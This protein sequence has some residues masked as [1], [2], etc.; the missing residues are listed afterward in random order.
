MGRHEKTERLIQAAHKI[1]RERHPMTVRQVY[2]QLVSGHVIK[3]DR[4]Q[5][6]AVSNALVMA[7]RE[8]LIPWN[9]IEDRIRKPRMVSM[10]N[11]VAHFAE[12][13]LGAYRLN[14][15]QTQPA[16]MEVWLE[17]DALSGIF[18]DVLEEYGVTLNVGRGYDGWSSI[19]NAARRYQKYQQRG[20][21]VYVS[22]WGDFDPS[23]EDMVRSL[24]ERLTSLGAYP[25]IAKI[26]LTR[27]DIRRYNLP[28]DFAKR[29]D[30]RA[31]AFIDQHG[32]VSVELD[33][34]PSDVLEEKL[35]GDIEGH[36]DM[37]ALA[38]TLALEAVERE[39]LTKL[40][41]EAG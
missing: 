15:W 12:S 25:A 40:L 23:G 7:R 9:W 8:G 18:E 24:E 3:N 31:K 17:K 32:D 35:R 41:K 6:S 11:G 37:S 5:Y 29:T 39:R 33:A 16:Y 34:L 20:M 21:A 2:Y 26:S 38:S 22:Y 30:T 4:S 1:L 36:M 28:P 27:D 10:W 13:V 14:V 19:H